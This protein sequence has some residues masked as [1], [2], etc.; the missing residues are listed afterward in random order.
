MHA[1]TSRP[2]YIFDLDGTVALIDHRRHLVAGK[3]RAWGAFFAACVHDAP[4]APVIRTM[5]QLHDSGAQLWI[6]SGRSDEVKAQTL[7][8]LQRHLPW[9]GLDGNTLRMRRQG[10]YTPDEILKRSWLHALAVDDRQRLIAIFDDRD[11]V[12][13]MWRA[14]GVTCFQ[15][16]AG[17]F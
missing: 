7:A 2:L 6:W 11:K 17:D 5:R 9:L 13:A 10:D 12:V 8:W 16:A 3:R 1:S 4:N 14:E 15:V